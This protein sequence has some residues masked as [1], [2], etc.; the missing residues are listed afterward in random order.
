MKKLRDRS[1]LP[2]FALIGCYVAAATAARRISFR[3]PLF[4]SHR[5]SR[6]FRNRSSVTNNDTNDKHIANC[7]AAAGGAPIGARKMAKCFSKICAGLPQAEKASQCQGA[8]FNCSSPAKMQTEVMQVP[9]II[10]S[11]FLFFISNIHHSTI[12]LIQDRQ[13]KPHKKHNVYL[14]NTQF[15]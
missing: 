1:T 9:P 2:C 10:I 5:A 4:I 3:V 7:Q 15:L 8:Q 6:C 14:Y 11:A 12:S 13:W